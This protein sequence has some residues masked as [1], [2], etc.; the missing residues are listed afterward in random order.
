MKVQ[1]SCPEWAKYLHGPTFDFPTLP[2]KGDDIRIVR[3]ELVFYTGLGGEVLDP[4]HVAFGRFVVKRRI[5]RD[6][7]LP[8]IVV[9]SR[10]SAVEDATLEDQIFSRDHIHGTSPEYFREPFTYRVGT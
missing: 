3:G 7:R 8:I 5:F 4:P 1:L 6:K 10:Y 9:K 2:E